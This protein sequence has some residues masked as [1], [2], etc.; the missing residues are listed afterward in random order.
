MNADKQDK[1]LFNKGDEANQSVDNDHM[2]INQPEL[3]FVYT[4]EIRRH[5]SQNQKDEFDKESDNTSYGC[6]QKTIQCCGDC[7]GFFRTWLPCIC[8]CTEYPWQVVKQSQQALM[9]RFGKYVRTLDPGLHYV[10]PCTEKLWRVDLKIEIIDLVKQVILTRDNITIMIDASVYYR[11]INPRKATY[12]ISNLGMA[13][14]QLTFSTLRCVCGIHT[15]Q[16]IL[17]KRKEIT[18]AIHQ[19]I[20]EHVEEWGIVIENVFMKDIVLNKDLQDALSSAAKER[21][22]AESKVISAKADVES[23]KMMREAAEALNSKSAMQIRYY[24]TIQNMVSTNNAKTIFLP[25]ET[26]FNA[27]AARKK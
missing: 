10:N 2:N 6:Y 26:K 17:E 27:E 22:L 19:Y 25:L 4:G 1:L 3:P 15:L 8:C 14:S 16:E 5:L 13:V 12:R 23:A 24:E 18:H 7:C 21:R 11:I 20:E 9:Q